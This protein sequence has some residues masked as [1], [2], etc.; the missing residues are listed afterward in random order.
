MA[1]KH[2]KFRKMADRKRIISEELLEL[3][4]K[5]NIHYK[6]KIAH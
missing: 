2:N 4:A 3:N 6:V 1:W 5:K